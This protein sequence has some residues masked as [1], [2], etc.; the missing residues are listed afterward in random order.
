MM[1]A[2][3]IYT[4]IIGLVSWKALESQRKEFEQASKG[5]LANLERLRDE[6]QL[7]FPML[8]RIQRN[9]K[10]I[11]ANLRAACELLSLKDVRDDSFSLLSPAEIQRILFYENAV[12]TALLLNTKGH[13]KELS[14]IYRLL[15]V[16]YGSKFYGTTEDNNGNNFGSSKESEHF[17]RAQFYFDRA[18]DLDPNNYTLLMQAGN[19]QQYYDNKTIASGSRSYFEMASGVEIQFQK[20]LVSIALIELEAFRN[21]SLTL[22]ALKRARSRKFYDEGRDARLGYI[23][24]LECCALCLRAEKENGPQKQSTLKEAAAKLADAASTPGKDWNA[25]HGFFDDDRSKYFTTLEREPQLKEEVAE[26]IQKLR[27]L[28]FDGIESN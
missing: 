9:F 8:G 24:Y 5:S 11:L 26:S 18:I 4:I 10:S 2:V 17:Y 23:A 7:D 28:V 15:G 21:P 3:G 6:F 22:K 27:L 25:I 1:T 20:P 19:F 12:T 14:E 16:F 13:E